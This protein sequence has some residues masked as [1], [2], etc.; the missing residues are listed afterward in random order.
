[1]L[2][3]TA[4]SH[5]SNLLSSPVDT[6]LYCYFSLPPSF[7]SFFPPPFPLRWSPLDFCPPW[8]APFCS[9]AVWTFSIREKQSTSGLIVLA[10]ELLCSCGHEV[11]RFSSLAVP[12]LGDDGLERTFLGLVRLEEQYLDLTSCFGIRFKLKDKGLPGT[13]LR[14]ITRLSPGAPRVRKTSG[15]IHA[16]SI[17]FCPFDRQE[18]NKHPWGNIF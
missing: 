18:S 14:G 2:L 16:W 6:L 12:G 5:T 13:G 8:D 9:W 7:L 17:F 4:V 15:N 11:S 3:Y 1:M 10:T